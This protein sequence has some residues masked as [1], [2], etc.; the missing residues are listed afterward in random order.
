M[1]DGAPARGG[2]R[3]QGAKSAG[4]SGPVKAPESLQMLVLPVI[5]PKFFV[6]LPMVGDDLPEPEPEPEP[7][8]AAAP[9]TP[10]KLDPMIR[11]TVPVVTPATCWTS[12]FGI[13]WASALA[14]AASEAALYWMIVLDD[15]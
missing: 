11:S 7:D 2:E 5:P 1:S 15:G 8:E 6:T 9:F 3:R 14:P 10:E 13:S 4:T 12:A